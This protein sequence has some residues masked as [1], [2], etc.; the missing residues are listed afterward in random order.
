MPMMMCIMA[1][2]PL[3]SYS[4]ILTFGYHGHNMT[5][6]LPSTKV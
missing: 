2:M 3:L 5:I 1:V 4:A 6:C